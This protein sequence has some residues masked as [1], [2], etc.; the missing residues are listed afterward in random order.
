MSPGADSRAPAVVVAVGVALFLVAAAHHVT[1]I[2][3]LGYPVGPI[4]AFV[5]DGGPA[6]GLAYAGYWLAHQDLDSAHAWRVTRWCL[7]GAAVFVATIG[8]SMGIRAIEERA[9]T[10]PVFTL[11]IAAEVGALA[12]FV[13]GYQRSRALLGKRRAEEAA[14]GLAVVNEIIR[15]DL[16]NDLQVVEA[17]AELIATDEEAE[18]SIPNHA[19]TIQ[20]RALAARERIEDTEAIANIMSENASFEAVDLTEVVRGVVDHVEDTYDV[21]VETDLPDST[22]VSANKGLRSV[23]DNLVENAVEHAGE[24]PSVAVSVE[25]G[26][27]TVG[28]VVRDDGP[29]LTAD[30]KALLSGSDGDDVGGLWIV[31]RLV[32]EYG[33]DIEATDNEPQGT[34]VRVDLP[35]ADR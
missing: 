22:V 6:L 10:E 2:V 30:Q 4:A 18:G 28:L 13:A 15:H 12:G 35:A 25:S 14:D 19:G 26:E 31:G 32:A 11:L 9:V 5:L 27:E 23:V 1:E 21:S 33:G 20:E 29:G 8:L 7:V 16:R 17:Y 34:V 24:D 3:R